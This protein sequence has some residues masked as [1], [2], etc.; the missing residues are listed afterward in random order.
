MRQP[1]ATLAHSPATQCTPLLNIIPNYKTAIDSQRLPSSTQTMV[2]ER[3]QKEE[4]FVLSLAV[5]IQLM[6][7][8]SEKK[9]L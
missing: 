8:H 7:L 4:T 2:D 3:K 5:I 6:P 9:T 1:L